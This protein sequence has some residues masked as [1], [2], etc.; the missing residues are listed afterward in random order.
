MYSPFPLLLP[1]FACGLAHQILFTYFLAYT[2]LFVCVLLMTIK[3]YLSAVFSYLYCVL[4]YVYA[5]MM[6][7]DKLK[8]NVR[9][10]FLKICPLSLKGG[11]GG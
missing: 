10:Q 1:I 9:F 6:M 3:T 8:K 4:M 11:P 7:K 2:Y 5:T